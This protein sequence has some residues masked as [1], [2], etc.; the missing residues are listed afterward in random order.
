[1]GP[2]SAPPFQCALPPRH[3]DRC[4]GTRTATA[5]ATAT[6]M[7]TTRARPSTTARL[8]RS[9]RT[10]SPG[11]SCLRQRSRSRSLQSSLMT[12]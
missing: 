3:V 11:R 5:A 1:M 6:T 2:S 4:A 9:W 10:R 12:T 7:T 8:T